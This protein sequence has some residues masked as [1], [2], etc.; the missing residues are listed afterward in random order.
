MHRACPGTHIHKYIK[1]YTGQK[2]LLMTFYRCPETTRQQYLPNNLFT[3]Y[4]YY[5]VILLSTRVNYG[6]LDFY[7]IDL[8]IPNASYTYHPAM[9][10]DF[11]YLHARHYY[12]MVVELQMSIIHVRW[13]L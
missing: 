7:N 12:N 9:T 13:S 8:L 4:N 1:V 3:I 5:I 6:R 10:S 2:L 11:A